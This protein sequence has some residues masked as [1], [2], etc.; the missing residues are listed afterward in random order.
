MLFSWYI[1]SLT[2]VRMFVCFTFIHINSTRYINKKRRSVGDIVTTSIHVYVL[3]SVLVY[4]FLLAMTFFL[5][6]VAYRLVYR[7]PSI[8]IARLVRICYVYLPLD[9]T[10][11]MAYECFIFEL[12]TYVR[13]WILETIMFESFR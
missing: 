3:C 13:N 5:Y 11:H 6:F 2:H 8:F 1:A 7:E 10:L 9:A 4:D 12:Y